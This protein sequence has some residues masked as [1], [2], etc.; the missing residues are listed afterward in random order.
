[1]GHDPALILGTDRS[2]DISAYYAA[3][4]AVPMPAGQATSADATLAASVSRT[5][6]IFARLGAATSASQYVSL[7]D[8][9][10]LQQSVDQVNQDYT[11]LGD[12]LNSY[13]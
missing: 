6:S 10:N 11:N 12:A 13:S 4:G 2:R 3:P 5:A 1:M 8:S 7:A 9:S